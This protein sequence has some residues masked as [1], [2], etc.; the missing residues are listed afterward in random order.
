MIPSERIND[1]RRKQRFP[2]NREVRYRLLQQPL[3]EH[4][5][6][7][8]INASSGGIAFRCDR[9]LPLNAL[10][11]FSVSWPVSLQ[12]SC[13]LR[14]VAKGRVVRSD[15]RSAA[16]T[17]DKFEFRTQSRNLSNLREALASVTAVRHQPAVCMA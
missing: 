7:T 2:L 12:D 15:G 11:E 14:L 4:G 8:A 16:C 13:P 3:E 6:G 9:P 5:V 17:I 1:R 10:I